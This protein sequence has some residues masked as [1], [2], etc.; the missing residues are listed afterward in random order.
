ME[1]KNKIIFI[2]IKQNIF[3]LLY[4]IIALTNLLINSNKIIIKSIITSYFY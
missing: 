2:V 3:C 4:D 1:N